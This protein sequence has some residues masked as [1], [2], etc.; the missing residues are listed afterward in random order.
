MKNK[1]PLIPYLF[2]I[3]VYGNQGLSGLPEQSITYLLKESWGYGAGMLGFIGFITGI[4]WYIKPAW[5]F[6]IDFCP[7]RKFRAKYYL[8]FNYFAILLAYLYI[9]IFGLNL[10]SLIITGLLINCFIGL[11]D[12]ANDSQMV[13][14]E[15]KYKMQGKLQAIQWTSLGI[16]GLFV[17]LGGAFIADKL[18]EPLNYKVAY[19]FAGIL[20]LITLIYLF[21]GYKETPITKR[22]K[23][24]DVGKDFKKILEP[25]LLLPLAF[26]ACF[27]FCP[28]FGTALLYEARD[29]LGVSKMFLGYLGATGTVL[30][31]VGYVLY[32]WKFHKVNMEKL[33]YFMVIF[34][35]V[36]NLFYL[37]IPNKW[38]LVG[39]NVAF[40]A[41]GGITF[42][43]LLAYFATL[44]PKGS[45]GM[46]YAVVTSV[47]NLCARGGS[48]LGG[49][50]YDNWGYNINVI[51]S[52]VLTL[53]CLFFIKHLHLKEDYNAN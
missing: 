33:I 7:I 37:Y 6:L 21:K 18:P 4:A 47:S 19:G 39:Y 43:T 44:I 32:Y 17:A 5:G 26:I 34:S 23:I 15:Q 14:Y 30:G 52:T 48:W 31:I 13:I 42:L 28:S 16:A 41:F 12:V 11:S 40:G 51:V 49:T 53:L 36:T 50:I 24:K 45:E 25:K 27:Q 3:L 8:Y 9:V 35:A 1:L 29:K 10:V 22:K 2:F 20:P 46:I 38:F